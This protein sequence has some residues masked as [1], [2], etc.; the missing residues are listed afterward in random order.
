MKTFD[1]ILLKNYGLVIESAVAADDAEKHSVRGL[2]LKDNVLNVIHRDPT[3]LLN[4]QDKKD[5]GTI[6]DNINLRFDLLN[7]IRASL[8]PPGQEKVAEAVQNVLDEIE[9]I[10]FGP[11]KNDKNEMI[12]VDPNFAGQYLDVQTAKKAYQKWFEFNK[13]HGNASKQEGVNKDDVVKENMEGAG[14]AVEEPVTVDKFLSENE[15]TFDQTATLK[16]LLPET[17]GKLLGHDTKAKG[18]ALEFSDFKM[19]DE[20]MFVQF[21]AKASD[22]FKTAVLVGQDGSMMTRTSYNILRRELKKYPDLFNGLFKKFRTGDLDSVASA[23]K[24]I[25]TGARNVGK[26]LKEQEIESVLALLKTS[27]TGICNAGTMDGMDKKY[28]AIW[29]ALKLNVPQPTFEGLEGYKKQELQAARLYEAVMGKIKSS[30]VVI[31]QL[32]GKVQ[33]IQLKLV[34]DGSKVTTGWTDKK[35]EKVKK[36]QKKSDKANKTDQ[37]VQ[38]FRIKPTR[39]ALKEVKLRSVPGGKKKG[40]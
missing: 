6:R 30:E 38:K 10:L 15:I 12:E 28:A 1:N 26:E 32:L 27:R 40:Y 13:A 18:Y 25:C 24:L 23:Y 34:K 14:D 8:V 17:V 35:D 22:G 31:P 21:A 33:R 37:K 11:R 36:E 20:G 7:K 19:I 9:A 5:R 2:V 3:V 16:S 4:V 29:R 39:N